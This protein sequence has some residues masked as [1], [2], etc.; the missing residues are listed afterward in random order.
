ML[1]F[2]KV[3]IRA[4][5]HDL[6]L[7]EV[8]QPRSLMMLPADIILLIHDFLSISSTTCLNLCSRQLLNIVENKAWHDLRSRDAS[9]RKEFLSMLKKD[10][11]N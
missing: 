4:V 8:P 2:V 10:L 9:E 1:P 5:F 7:D 3:L 6:A 11:S